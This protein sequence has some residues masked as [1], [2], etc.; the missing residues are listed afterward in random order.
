[1]WLVTETQ[2]SILQALHLPLEGGTQSQLPQAIATAERRSLDLDLDSSGAP[3]TRDPA[4]HLPLSDISL[5]HK[6]SEVSLLCALLCVGS[7]SA[8]HVH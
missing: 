7:C 1:M 4:L 6:Q 5:S 2:W 3:P 8:H